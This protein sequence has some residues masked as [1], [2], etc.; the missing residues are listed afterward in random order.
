MLRTH[1]LH[2]LENGAKTL[3]PTHDHEPG[4]PPRGHDPVDWP[5]DPSE[6]RSLSRQV[7]RRIARRGR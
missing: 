6:G 5:Q 1:H 4:Q 3:Y 7:L 2:I